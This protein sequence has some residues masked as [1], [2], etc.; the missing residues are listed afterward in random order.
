MPVTIWDALCMC[1]LVHNVIVEICKVEMVG[2]L[3]T[4]RGL[5]VI[6]DSWPWPANCDNSIG[7]LY[8]IAKMK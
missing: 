7:Y 1:K 8:F 5:P 6:E 2:Q 3:L 4:T